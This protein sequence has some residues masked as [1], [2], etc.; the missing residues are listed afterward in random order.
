[1]TTATKNWTDAEFMTLPEDGHRYELM[2]GKE[3]DI[4]NAGMEH[5]EMGS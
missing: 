3:V 5:G 1:M 2:N 4:G